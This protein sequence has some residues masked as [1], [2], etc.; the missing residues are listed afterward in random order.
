MARLT[1]EDLRDRALRNDEVQ[2]VEIESSMLGGSLLAVRLPTR[3]VMEIID[4]AGEDLASQYEA[5]I[6]LI[7]ESVPML[8]DQ[9]LMTLVNAA[10]PYD[11]VETLFGGN[12]QEI[13]SLAEKILGMYG[14]AEAVDELK[15]S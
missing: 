13:G 8:R 2:S 10:E 4:E 6:R 11:V 1:I 14:M 7:Y 9:E 5:N 15:N 12:I 3:R